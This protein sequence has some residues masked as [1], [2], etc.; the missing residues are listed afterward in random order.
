[1]IRIIVLEDHAIVRRCLRDL[2]AAS[3]DLDVVGAAGS[4]HEALAAVDGLEFAPRHC[5]ADKLT[6]RGRE[7][8]VFLGTGA[9]QQTHR[10]PTGHHREN[11]EGPPISRLRPHRR[12]GPHRG[13]PVGSTTQRLS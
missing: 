12:R 2:L 7:V 5:G 9:D 3:P 8:L 13:S 1:M 4:A 11:G 10:P 6:P